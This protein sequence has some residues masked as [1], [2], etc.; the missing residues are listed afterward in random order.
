MK[1]IFLF[2]LTNILVMLSISIVYSLLLA[3]GL[4]PPGYQSQIV[5][6]SLLIG[7]GGS[8]ISLLMSKWMAK[9][10]MGVQIVDSRGAYAPLVQKVHTLAKQAGLPKMPEVGVY[11][12]AEVN[13]FATG[14][15]K[16]NSLVAVSTGLLNRMDD[17]E[18]HGVLAHEVAH[19]A[20]GD[21]VTMTLVQGVVNSFTYL[22]SIIVTNI[23]AAALRGNSE[24]GM[25]DNFFVRQMI[26]SAVYSLVAF[27]A[28]PI[29][30]AFSRYREY[31]ADAGGAKLA[32]THDMVAALEKLKSHVGGVE[33]QEA[34]FQSMKI[35][36]KGSFAE[37]FSTHPPLEKRIRALQARRG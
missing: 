1:R 13:A 24:R 22:V 28:Y 20:N 18:V 15:S 34:A 2:F 31:R 16:S 27:A 5:V 6:F 32:G 10:M 23:I 17:A 7:F 12:S 9:Q 35:S 11:E 29:V 36:N 25:G 21:M 33:Q 26:F 19:I 30:A 37:W 3:T 14:P 4:V 8:F